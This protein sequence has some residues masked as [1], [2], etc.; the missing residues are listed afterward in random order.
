V[1]DIEAHITY[2]S[3]TEDTG[4]GL[5]KSQTEKQKGQWVMV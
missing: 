4:K 3:K 1:E 5:I 2:G